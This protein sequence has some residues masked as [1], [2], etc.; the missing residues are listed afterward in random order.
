MSMK[1]KV[2]SRGMNVGGCDYEYAPGWVFTSDPACADYDW[3]VVYDEM[4]TADIGTLRGG[5]E[6]LACPWEHTILATC[7]PTSIKPYSTAYTHQF[8]HLLT[9]RPFSSERH[10]GYFLGRGYYNW[11]TERSPQENVAHVFPPKTDGVSVVCSDKRMTH[12]KH[13]ARYRLVRAFAEAMPELVWYGHGVRECANKCAVL[14][15]FKYHLAIEN[16]IAPHHWSEKIADAFL[17]ECLPFYAGAPDLA[18]DLPRESF[19]PIPIDDP[20]EAVRIVKAAVA[21][22]AYAQRREAILEARRLILT[23]YNFWAQVIALIETSSRGV[24]WSPRDEAAVPSCIC[25]RKL[26]RRRHLGAALE[27]GWFRFRQCLHLL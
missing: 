5:C 22:N 15:P 10:P 14:D 23:K 1:I 17:C 8:A 12:T 21:E 6:P 11:L 18:D 2:I 16:H 20:A 4:E 24:R 19:I 27:E 25:E 13:G 7:E 9:N 3:L 26:V